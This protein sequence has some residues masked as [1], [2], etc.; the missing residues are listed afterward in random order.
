MLA[1]HYLQLE[2]KGAEAT[3]ETVKNSCLGIS[4]IFGADFLSHSWVQRCLNAQTDK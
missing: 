3:A 1:I 4:Y 2:L